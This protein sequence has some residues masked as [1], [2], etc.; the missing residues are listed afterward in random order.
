MSFI[1]ILS[2]L[3]FCTQN[4]KQELKEDIK[5]NKAMLKDIW[6][7]LN[8][9]QE[10]YK[11]EVISLDNRTSVLEENQQKL[12]LDIIDKLDEM[13]KT[14]NANS[15]KMQDNLRK[16]IIELRN[17]FEEKVSK[18][19]DNLQDKVILLEQNQQDNK[20]CIAEISNTLHED[21]SKVKLHQAEKCKAIEDMLSSL[22]RNQIELKTD[23]MENL[24]VVNKET[25]DINKNI[26]SLRK[27]ID[28]NLS[29]QLKK[30]DIRLI[31]ELLRLFIANNFLDDINSQ[32]GGKNNKHFTEKKLYD[33]INTLW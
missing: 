26:K 32:Q 7:L 22:S 29:K 13:D 6:I 23:I 4:D 27:T 24:S 20:T 17:M 15:L 31:E 11:K 28:N 19:I 10:Q 1:E 21:L 2:K 33:N 30:E 18:Q 9:V 12:H 14:I 3:G 5:Q 8:T 16:C 25:D